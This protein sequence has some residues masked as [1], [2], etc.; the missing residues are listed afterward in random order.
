[1]IPRV[2]TPR[3]SSLTP[4][5]IPTVPPPK[6]RTSWPLA[7]RLLA[8]LMIPEDKGLGDTIERKLG[9]GGEIMKKWYRKVIGRECGCGSRK[10]KLNVLFPNSDR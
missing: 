10:D 5:T 8:W 7:A 6:P 2:Y 3:E 4:V 1:M 9:T